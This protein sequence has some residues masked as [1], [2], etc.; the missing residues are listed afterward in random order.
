MSTSVSLVKPHYVVVVLP[1]YY[2]LPAHDSSRM[3]ERLR[4]RHSPPL[5]PTVERSLLLLAFDNGV[6]KKAM[7]NQIESPPN[8]A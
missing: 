3:N 8:H 7:Q 1:L 6:V 4:A 5:P 2:L